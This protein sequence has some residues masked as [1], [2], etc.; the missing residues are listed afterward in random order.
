LPREISVDI[1]GLTELGQS[2]YVKD[3]KFPPN[4]KVAIDPETVVVSVSEPLKEEE[5]AP[6]PVAVEDVKVEGEE[7]KAER[8]AAKEAETHAETTPEN[9]VQ[10]TPKK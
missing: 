8:D 2:I 10:P 3:L 4:V 7:K 6:E 9:K 5:I 1:S